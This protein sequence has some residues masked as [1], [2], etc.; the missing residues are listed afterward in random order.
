MAVPAPVLSSTRSRQQYQYR[1]YRRWYPWLPSPRTYL[2]WLAI[3]PCPYVRRHRN[4]CRNEK[5]NT[6]SP[7]NSYEPPIALPR[8]SRAAHRR[9]P[10]LL[11]PHLLPPI[12]ALVV[13]RPGA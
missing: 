2:S 12:L 6:P 7:K 11:L 4:C 10:L 5:D 1:N 3:P 8:S 9:K 13:V